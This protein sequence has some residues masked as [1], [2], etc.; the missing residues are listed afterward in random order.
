MRNLHGGEIVVRSRVEC[1]R[2]DEIE[3]DSDLSMAPPQTLSI[4]S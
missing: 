3:G 2:T 4:S 1:G